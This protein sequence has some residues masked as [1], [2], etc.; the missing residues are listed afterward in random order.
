MTDN[1][2]SEIMVLLARLDERSEQ[3]AR[4]TCEFKEQFKDLRDKIDGGQTPEKGIIQRLALMERDYQR[5]GQAFWISITA[6]LGVI[7]TYVA[8]KLGL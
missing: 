8:N 7:I 4:D 2:T 6:A 3:Q 1:Q 5:A